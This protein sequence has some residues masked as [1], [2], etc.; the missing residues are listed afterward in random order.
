MQCGN[1]RA[2]EGSRRVTKF[3][4]SLLRRITT[5]GG[6]LGTCI[7]RVPLVGKK[8]AGASLFRSELRRTLANICN[9]LRVTF[10]EWFVAAAYAH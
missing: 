9:A 2:V 5:K 1:G 8:L 7:N 6:K 4:Q 10:K 3:A